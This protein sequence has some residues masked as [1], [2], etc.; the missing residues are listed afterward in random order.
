MTAQT[1]GSISSGITVN[2]K[3]PFIEFTVLCLFSL[4]YIDFK[5]Q[6]DYQLYAPFAF[7]LY[8]G[9]CYYKERSLRK[10]IFIGLLTCTIIASLFQ[11]ITVPITINGTMAGGK[12]FY[13]NFTQYLMCFFPLAM[14][15]R[16]YYR[17]SRLQTLVILGVTLTAAMILVQ[18]ALVFAE[19]DPGILHTMDTE[20]LEDVDID[21]QGYNYVYAFTFLIIACLEILKT[22]INIR[23]R[24]L[25]GLGLLYSLYFLFTAQFALS[26]VTTF[27]S[28]LY[29]FYIST[30]NT[31]LKIVVIIG[32]IVI[33]FTLPTLLELLI[34]FT[35]DS[36]ILNTRLREIY[37]AITG[38][39][40]NHSDLQARLDLYWLSIQAFL[41]SPIFGNAYL[42][43]NGHSTFLLGFAYLGIFGGTLICW[44]FYK[45]AKF[46]EIIMGK[47]Y[48]YFRPL[49][50]QI[51]LMGL[52]NPIQASPSN[53]IMLFFVCP[54]I[55]MRYVKS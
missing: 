1:A 7:L 5:I 38:N 39:H 11:I 30:K 31:A 17:A 21:L 53:F 37:N 24:C 16:V 40:S 18:A 34:S 49:M 20:K 48:Y 32:I 6:G 42:P 41:R 4:F 28:C 10:T 47:K 29:L 19:I 9:Y 27:I 15:Y 2:R 52:T 45:G 23:I 55:L 25:A 50:L 54:L 12:Y 14:L 26:I 8:L 36:D 22:G 33:Y 35:Q 43:F 44:I 13:S 46:T 3:L 51:V